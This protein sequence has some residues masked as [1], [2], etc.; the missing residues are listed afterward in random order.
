MRFIGE[1]EIDVLLSTITQGD[2]TKF[3]A[4]SHNLWKRFHNYEKAPPMA[5]MN[6]DKIVCLHYA[7]FN[8]NKYLNSYEIVTMEGQEGHGYASKLWEE[9]MNY[10]VMEMGITRL[11]NSCIASSIT[12]H[13]KH[14]LIFWGIDPTGSLKSDQPLYPSIKAQI[15]AFNVFRKNHSLA[16]PA[17][18]VLKSM[19]QIDDYTFS[20]KKQ[21]LIMEAVN[22]AGDHWFG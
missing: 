18:S 17:P 22:K 4:A 14:G 5:L 11:K 12:W 15:D 1:E 2:N 13:I 8:K 9:S 7:T 10:A 19:K 16:E 20:P 21:R 3:L 6:D